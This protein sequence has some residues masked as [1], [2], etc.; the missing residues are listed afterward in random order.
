MGDPSQPAQP[1]HDE[2]TVTAPADHTLCHSLQHARAG[3]LADV[4]V[5]F[6]ELG[7]RWQRDA[8]WQDSWGRSFAMCSECWDTTR[9]VAEN[10]RPGLVVTD[11]RKGAPDGGTARLPGR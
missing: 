1:G 6:L 2:I 5:T 4:V 9:Q 10:A 3:C 8:L 7:T 11:T